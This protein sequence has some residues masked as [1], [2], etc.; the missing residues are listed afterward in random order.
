MRGR[1]LVV[2]NKTTIR[3]M[4]ESLLKEYKLEVVCFEESQKGLDWLTLSKVDLKVD[5]LILDYSLTEP[6][7]ITFCQKVRQNQKLVNIPIIVLLTLEE[8]RDGEELKKQGASNFVL[9]PF[10]PKELIEKVEIYLLEKA[11]TSSQEPVPTAP[12]RVKGPASQAGDIF[13]GE[14]ALDIDS[15]LSE[16]K[17]TKENRPL[18]DLLKPVDEEISI[19]STPW[20]M[21]LEPEVKP[22][23]PSQHDYGWFLQEM[24]QEGKKGKM[25]EKIESASL[26]SGQKV[27][28]DKLPE[29]IKVK[30]EEM[31][32][33]KVNLQK[34]A[35]Q[36]NAKEINK[37]EPALPGAPEFNPQIVLE[38]EGLISPKRIDTPSP[39]KKHESTKLISGAGIDYQKITSELTGKVADRLA[40]E[41][42]QRLKPET[43]IQLLKDELERVKE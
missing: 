32:T 22:E 4:V 5:L 41:L 36:M 29:Q 42:V 25:E 39:S 17:S 2:I 6:S 33:S 10:N 19:E 28:S 13:A 8:M 1:I 38:D 12:S 37:P 31:G 18:E 16:A 40:K 9:K 26:Q 21:D 23:E 35:S 30:V 11:A 34:A 27:I 7:V 43:I 3:S 14:G 20:G 15:I 24:Q